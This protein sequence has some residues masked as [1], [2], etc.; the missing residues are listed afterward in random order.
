MNGGHQKTTHTTRSHTHK[1]TIA[2]AKH[3][4]M[5]TDKYVKRKMDQRRE[6][7][8]NFIHFFSTDF[9]DFTCISFVLKRLEVFL[10]KN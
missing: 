6:N 10:I 7:F 1:Q 5:T 2:F 9:Q 4:K 8:P 3:K